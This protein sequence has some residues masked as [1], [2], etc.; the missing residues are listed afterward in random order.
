VAENQQ[1]HS[2][3]KPAVEPGY[4]AGPSSALNSV[5]AVPLQTSSGTIGVLALYRTKE[6]RVFSR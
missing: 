1:G 3:R 6:R 2:E 5:L 4:R